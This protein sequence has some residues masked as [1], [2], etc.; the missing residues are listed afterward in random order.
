VSAENDRGRVADDL[1][2]DHLLLQL[3]LPSE[4]QQEL[5]QLVKEQLDPGS[6]NFHKWLTPAEFRQE[7]SLASKAS[8]I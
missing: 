3:R 6:P 8:L 2:L 5:D 4:K 1:P 7:F